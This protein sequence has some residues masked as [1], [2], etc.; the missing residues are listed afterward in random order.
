[1]DTEQLIDLARKDNQGCTELIRSYLR[2]LKQRVENKEL[3]PATVALYFATLKLFFS[4]NDITFN[5]TKLFKMLP[6]PTTLADR[7]Y[8]KE[9]IKAMLKHADLREK[10]VI[11]CLASGGIRIGAFTE[12]LVKHA[13][14]IIIDNVLI[15][16]MLVV[17]SDTPSEYFT[18]VTPECYH[19]IE[20]YLEY[21]KRNHEKILPD[22]P[23]IRNTI[24]Q[25]VPSKANS[26]RNARK[27]VTG[28]LQMI[29]WRLLIRAGVRQMTDTK[30]YDVKMDHGFRK[31]FN[32]ECKRA[33]VDP[34]HKEMFLGHTVG[35]EDSYY[36]PEEDELLQDYLKV[37]PHLTFDDVELV[38]LEN[39][40]LRKDLTE[41][42]QLKV[43]VAEFE[44]LT[45]HL[46]EHGILKDTSL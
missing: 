18:F 45:N 12:L 14:P 28:T 31:F 30:R 2:Q 15:G 40:E 19:A 24:R 43:K 22:A 25:G 13:T 27:L 44:E 5:W 42:E 39:L 1:M 16:G 37:A 4:M 9:E 41:I 46:K 8:T 20:D 33:K 21:R 3:Q 17:Y 34:L 7:S 10:V 11:L 32:T 35:L 29:I 36:R 23:L 38:R 26:Q 6:T